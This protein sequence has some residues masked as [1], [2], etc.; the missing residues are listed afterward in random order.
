ML[1]PRRQHQPADCG[2]RTGACPEA[3]EFPPFDADYIVTV[4]DTLQFQLVVANASPDKEF[5]Y[6]E[7]LHTYFAVGDI[8]AVSVTLD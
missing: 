2:S 1:T 4:S 6:E 8:G 3:A 7:C 5:V